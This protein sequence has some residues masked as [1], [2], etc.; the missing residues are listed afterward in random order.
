[1]PCH[2]TWPFRGSPTRFRRLL[3]ARS[4][5]EAAHVVAAGRTRRHAFLTH[6]CSQPADFVLEPEEHAKIHL[7]EAASGPRAHGQRARSTGVTFS[8]SQPRRKAHTSLEAGWWDRLGQFDRTGGMVFED[9]H[10]ARVPAG[11]LY[12]REGDWLPQCMRRSRDPAAPADSTKAEQKS[13][14]DAFARR[15]QWIRANMPQQGPHGQGAPSQPE[16]AAVSEVDAL[17]AR[18]LARLQY[19]LWHLRQEEAAIELGVMPDLQLA[20][21]ALEQ[22]RWDTH[23]SAALA[24]GSAAV[25]S[26]MATLRQGGQAGCGAWGDYRGLLHFARD[27]PA[28]AV[29]QLKWYRSALQS[30]AATAAARR[31]AA[32]SQAF[33]AEKAKAAADSPDGAAQLQ[34]SMLEAEAAVEAEEAVEAVGGLGGYPVYAVDTVDQRAYPRPPRV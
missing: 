7:E 28:A 18:A 26:G 30:H 5:G 32:L 16:Q 31:T 1:M 2:N 13:T 21:S 22:G 23:S 12:F 14:M 8:N 25:E 34:A 11:W 9:D 4:A 15:M 19:V 6:P 3:C 33:R 29:G 24:S 20:E 27:D 17:R 10:I